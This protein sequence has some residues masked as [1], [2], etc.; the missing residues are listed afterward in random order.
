MCIC[1][2]PY[3]T[4]RAIALVIRLYSIIHLHVS[5]SLH[6]LHSYFIDDYII[7]IIGMPALSHLTYLPPPP[8]VNP[9]YD[10]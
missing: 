8:C 6:V 1:T 7:I 4:A 5:F 9:R 10:Y 2:V 3:F